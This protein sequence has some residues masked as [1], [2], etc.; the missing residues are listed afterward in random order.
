VDGHL[1]TQRDPTGSPTNLSVRLNAKN[2]SS[3]VQEYSIPNHPAAGEG[4]WF[5]HPDKNIDIAAVRV[6]WKFLQDNG[7]EPNFFANDQHV[8]NTVKLKDL[9]ITAG[10]GIFVL[11]FPMNLTGTQRNYVI[12]REGVI[13]RISEMLDG[14][15]KSFM[16]DALVFPGNSGGPVVLKPEI[17]SIQGTKSQSAA[18][19]IGIVLSYIP[20]VDVAVS[21]QTHHPRITFEEN[22]GLV[23]VLPTDY[24]DEAIKVYR[25]T[26]PPA[27]LT[28]LIVP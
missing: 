3:G 21:T 7:F 5:Y 12:V 25:S 23:E 14:A 24:I 19:L 27:P 18:Y 13:A 16:L 6:N 10:D 28:P 22:S 8:A 2:P 15:S 9:E 4:T 11:G 1:Q 20:Y 26:L 17:S